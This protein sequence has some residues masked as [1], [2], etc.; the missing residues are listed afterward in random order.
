M[1][2]DCT[3]VNFTMRIVSVYFKNVYPAFLKRFR[4]KTIKLIVQSYF[5]PPST[6]AA[7]NIGAMYPVDGVNQEASGGKGEQTL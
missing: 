3:Y 6:A 4:L 1:H 7:S 2:N 5:P